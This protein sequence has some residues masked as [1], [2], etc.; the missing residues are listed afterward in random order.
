MH[1]PPAHR[2]KGDGPRTIVTGVDGSPTSLRAAAY[3]AGLARRQGARMV[4]VH[5]IRPPFG[6]NMAPMA[7]IELRGTLKEIAEQVRDDVHDGAEHV[8]MQVEFV[9]AD[10]DPYAQLVR[11]TNQLG[12]DALVVG[13]S[14]RVGHRIVGSLA[15]RLVRS[16]LWPVTVVP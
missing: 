9:T 7:D 11:V 10:G 6:A 8:G 4:A 16:G 3:A 2:P 13:A 15:V 14:T 12:A 5:V 1:I